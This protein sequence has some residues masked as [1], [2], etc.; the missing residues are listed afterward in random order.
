MI[1]EV[2]IEGNRQEGP[3]AY[4]E[5]HG[6]LADKGCL[7]TPLGGG[8]KVCVSECKCE[9]LST[10]GGGLLGDVPGDGDIRTGSLL[11]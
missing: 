6:P 9:K 3:R 10:E 8:V 2:R 7:I 4:G 5:V 1:G 11:P